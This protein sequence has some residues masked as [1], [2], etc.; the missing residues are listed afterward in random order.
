MGSQGILH[1]VGIKSLIMITTMQNTDIL[2]AHSL[3]MFIEPKFL[4]KMTWMQSYK[5]KE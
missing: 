1:L 3:L 4:I 2:G 5:I